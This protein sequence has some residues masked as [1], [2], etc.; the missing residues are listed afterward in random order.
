VCKLM[1]VN[2]RP[3][4]KLSDNA[5]KSTGPMEEIARYRRVFG[6]ELQERAVVV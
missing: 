2:G 5:R 6:S 4:V 1:T 3:A